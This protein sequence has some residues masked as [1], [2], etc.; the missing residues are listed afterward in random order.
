MS[1]QAEIHEH[2]EPSD[3]PP[4]SREKEDGDESNS[5]SF[6]DKADMQRLG[7]EQEL[8]VCRPYS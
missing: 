7:K 5:G 2:R 8:K 3:S 6:Y 4:N 1:K